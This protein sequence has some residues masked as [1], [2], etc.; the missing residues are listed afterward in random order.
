MLSEDFEDG[1]IALLRTQLQSVI[2]NAK[3]IEE[4]LIFK[5]WE[6]V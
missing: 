2:N 3:S 5:V 4:K 6:L 1:E